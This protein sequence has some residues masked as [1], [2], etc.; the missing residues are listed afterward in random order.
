MAAAPIRTLFDLQT[1]AKLAITAGF[2]L[3]LMSA[4]AT[5]VEPSVLRL[6]D[7]LRAGHVDAA[8][9]LAEWMIEARRLLEKMKKALSMLCGH[10]QCG[11]EIVHADSEVFV[12]VI[13]RGGMVRFGR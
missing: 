4:P 1:A 11:E 3:P 7:M 8:R 10:P 12:M 9:A 2:V 5:R 13:D 6:R